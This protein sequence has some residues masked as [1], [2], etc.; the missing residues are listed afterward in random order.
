MGNCCS[1]QTVDNQGDIQ[2][3]DHQ[4]LAKRLTA[5]QLALVIKVQAHMRGFL[6]RKRIRAVHYNAGMGMGGFVYGEDGEIQQDYDNPKVQVSNTLWINFLN[7][8]SARSLENLTTIRRQITKI[9]LSSI[10]QWL[11]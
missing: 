10:D 6:T 11:S 7:R 9:S 5:S 1:G 8:K 4:Q 3:L 2:T